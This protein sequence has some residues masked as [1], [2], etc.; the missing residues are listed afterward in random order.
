[1]NFLMTAEQLKNELDTLR[2]LDNEA[3]ARI[4]QKFRLDW[5]YHSNNLE[6]NSLTY[7]ETK[8]LILFGITAQGKPLKDHFEITGH[9]EAINWIL[10]IVKDETP[11]TEKFIRELHSLLLKESSYKEAQTPNGKPTR[12]KI[13]VGKY[14]T[15][16]NHVNTVTG[17]IF[18]FATPEETP[19][20][21]QELIEWFRKEKEKPDVNPVILAALFHY[22]FIRIHPFDD[23]NGR[24]ARILMNFILIQFGYPPVIIKTEDKENYYAVLRLA[25]ADELE[26]FIEYITENLVRSLEIMIRGAKGESIEEHND[27]DK[28]LSL[29]EASLTEKYKKVERVKT[30]ESFQEAFHKS[31]IPLANTLLETWKKFDRLYIESELIIK[32][33]TKHHL[34]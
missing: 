5:N 13:E 12:R 26:P 28:Q 17:E 7:G 15:L 10:E 16:P 25:D 32:V 3:E 22:R 6:G 4:M 27:L 1:M 8:A 23:G 30:K 11:L 19:A 31:I 18:Y 2:P 20:K 24:V 14:K 34:E 33:E 21:M 9:N 29:F